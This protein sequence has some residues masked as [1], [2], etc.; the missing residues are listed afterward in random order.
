MQTLSIITLIAAILLPALDYFVLRQRRGST[1][2]RLIGFERTLY[3][4]FLVALTAMVLSGIVMLAGGQRMGGWMLMLHMSASPVFALCI[5]GLALMWRNQAQHA[6]STPPTQCISRS[7]KLAFCIV[8]GVSFVTILSAMLGM[9]SWFGSECQIFLLN[10]HRV[11]AFILLIAAAYQA[12][13]LLPQR[14]TTP[15]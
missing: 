1:G 9:M 4:L 7:E 6:A 11:G 3:L 10:V 2:P 13:R 5:T 8:I 12:A 15:R 14:A